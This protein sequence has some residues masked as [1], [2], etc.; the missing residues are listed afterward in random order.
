MNASVAF[1]STW[2]KIKGHQFSWL[3]AILFVAQLI[4]GVSLAAT[5]DEP[6][7]FSFIKSPPGEFIQLEYHRLHVS[8]VGEGPVTV[9]FEPGL[10]GSAFEWDVIQQQ[11]AE[12][13]VA[14][15]YD[16]AG[17]GWSD[18]SPFTGS[19]RQLASEANQ[20]LEQVADNNKLI[21]VGHSFG[22]FVVRMLAKHR[23]QQV[24]G[25]VLVDASHEEQLERM[26]TPGKTKI[27][28]SGNTFV[29]NRTNIPDNL[30]KE[31]GRKIA[32][33]LRMRKSYIAT[34]REM[35]SF[36]ESVKQ[37]KLLDDDYSIPLTVIHRGLNPMSAEKDGEERHRI[38]GELQQNLAKLSSDGDVIVAQESGHHVHIDEPELVV[39]AIIGMLNKE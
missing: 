29:I 17:Y 31:A 39:D 32:A 13:A 10:G 7:D 8:C 36:R 6:L 3:L 30:P 9:L 2:L 35:R 5:E 23:L 15:V 22:G 34:E 1:I 25:M 16:R 18:P 14:C 20:M 19:V 11:I 26:E 21:L 38:W 4:S 33:F 28:P 12:H 24:I 27:L 37:I